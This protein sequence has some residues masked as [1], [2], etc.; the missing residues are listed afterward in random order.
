M[1][2]DILLGLLSLDQ[3]YAFPIYMLDYLYILYK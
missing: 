3:N 2:Q 1:L